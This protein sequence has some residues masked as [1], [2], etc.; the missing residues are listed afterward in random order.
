[1]WNFVHSRGQS[2]RHISLWC[3]DGGNATLCAAPCS[4][5]KSNGCLLDWQSRCHLLCCQVCL[6]QPTS[7]W[8]M[9]VDVEAEASPQSAAGLKIVVAMS[10]PH[11]WSPVVSKLWALA[12]PLLFIICLY[13]ANAG[14]NWFEVLQAETLAFKGNKDMNSPRRVGGMIKQFN[15]HK[16]TISSW[17]GYGEQSKIK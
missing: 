17:G 6:W 13:Q 5:I 15:L 12:F 1:M 16:K 4:L 11:N 3:R 8:W 2:S 9:A 7:F 10:D 14:C